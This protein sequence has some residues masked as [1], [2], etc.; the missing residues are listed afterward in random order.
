MN[1]SLIR[2]AALVR[3]VE[4]FKQWTRIQIRPILPHAAFVCTFGHV[5]ARGVAIDGVVTVDFPVGHLDA[6]RDPAGGFESPILQRLLV[7][8]EV[9][10]FD[11]DQPWPDVPQP[12]LE[13]YRK[14]Q[15]G[16][17]VTSGVYDRQQCVATSHSF[18]RVAE[19]LGDRHIS[20]AGELVPLMH[21]L[22]CRVRL[23]QLKAADHFST[24]LA[25]LS[26]PELEALGWLRMG[27]SNQDIAQL[28]G[29]SEGAI[30]QRIGRVFEK[31]GIENRAQMVR[32]LFEHENQRLAFSRTKYL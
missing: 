5:R 21:D 23:E 11:P 18:V 17:S 8:R 25:R 1:E 27:K 19:P 29:C 7:T 4:E 12:W 6:I 32:S 26:Q 24:Q 22:F 14:H 10:L 16:R 3:T 15:L 30:K 9:Q 28:L 31:L 2:S 20:L 13:S